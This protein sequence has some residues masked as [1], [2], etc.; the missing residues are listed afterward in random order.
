MTK[1]SGPLRKR[2]IAQQEERH[3][4]DDGDDPSP[5][6]KDKEEAPFTPLS[7]TRSR[8]EGHPRLEA[9]WKTSGSVLFNW[10]H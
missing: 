4:S 1:V 8:K 3:R 9:K 2:K 7:G 5:G 10:K 6:R